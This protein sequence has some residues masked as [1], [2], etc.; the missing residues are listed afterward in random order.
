[1]SCGRAPRCVRPVIE[2]SWAR[3]AGAG[4]DPEEL[5]PRAAFDSRGLE[6]IRAS[7]RLSEVMPVLRRCLGA[8]AEDAEHVVVVCDA[9]GRVLWMEG[10]T[11]VK[12]QA[13]R[14]TFGEGMLWTED[15]AG[16]N[17]I[18]TALAIDHA[19]QIFS[20]EHFLP[21]QHRW[22]CSAAPIHDPVTGELLGIVDLSGPMRTAHPHSLAL[23]MAAAA[24]AENVLRFQQAVE[25]ERLRRLYAERTARPGHD[26]SA[27]VAADGRVLIAQPAG[28][29]EG[30]VQ[31]PPEGGPLTLPSGRQAVAEALD[32]RGGWVLREAVRQAG[33]GTTP[34]LL[35]LLGRHALSARLGKADAFELSLRRAEILALLAMHPDGLSAEQLTLYLYGEHGN[36]ITT[37]AEM[38]RLRKLLGP[39]L[40]AKPYRLVAD[41]KADFLEVERLLAAGELGRALRRYRGPLLVES[42]A[43]RIEQARHELEGALRRA[44]MHG[45]LEHLWGWLRNEAGRDD[46]PAMAEYL[47]R[48]PGDDPHRPLIDARLRSLRSRWGLPAPA[49]GT[50]P[51]PGGTP[52]ASAAARR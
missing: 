38:S 30:V 12:H 47:R 21:E 14:I 41:V 37:R 15:S 27:L 6:D 24:M 1:M 39:W 23:V 35:R 2:R 26:A 28:W 19:V 25:D 44:V 51:L 29:A 22:W 32:G 5:H 50:S 7:S 31:V 43:P 8:L 13:D 16:T 11:R 49:T 33:P 36:R 48:A 40:A 18:G 42:E 20:A 46:P 34:L 10:H 9:A 45:P 17:A 52:R 4:L 3:M